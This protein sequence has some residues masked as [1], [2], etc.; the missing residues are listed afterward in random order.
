MFN[1]CI[2]T[3]NANPRNERIRKAMH[4]KQ[5]K[6][7]EKPNQNMRTDNR[8]AKIRQKKKSIERWKSQDD[9]EIPS[10]R[11]QPYW[12]ELVEKNRKQEERNC[13]GYADAKRNMYEGQATKERCVF[14]RLSVAVNM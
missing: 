11:Y 4:A 2:R 6:R 14:A 5:K 9:S 8:P 1:N 13:G 7:Q 12:M 3:R 10:Q